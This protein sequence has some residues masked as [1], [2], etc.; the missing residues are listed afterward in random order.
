MI[1]SKVTVCIPTSPIPSHPSTYIIEKVLKS[2][3]FHLPEAKIIV[4][5]DG[6]RKSVEYRR[7]QYEQYIQN[8]AM[9]ISSMKYGNT[10]MPIF[11]KPT[12]QTGMMNHVLKNEIT[13]PLVLFIEHDTF[14]VTDVNP[15]DVDGVTRKEDCPIEWDE[16]AK[17]ILSGQLNMVRFYAWEKIWHEHEYLMCGD[18]VDGY[19]RFVKTKQYS[20][21]PNIAS[22]VF[23]KR[24]LV[25]HFKPTDAFMIEPTMV[26]PVSTHPWEDYKIAIYHPQPNAR[27]FYHMNG[28]VGSDGQKDPSDW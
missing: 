23:Y 16:I 10:I 2:V 20:Q 27:R 12:Q 11:E 17:V 18:F 8:L 6:V 5:A 28:R 26:S 9:V 15:R 13:T 14:L 21:W 22:T 19:T 1:D 25:E 4:M 24:I 7:G 3:R